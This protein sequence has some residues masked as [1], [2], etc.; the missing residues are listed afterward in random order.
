MHE[1]LG[2]DKVWWSNHVNTMVDERVKSEILGTDVVG[3]TFEDQRSALVLEIE[4]HLGSVEGRV[5]ETVNE[6]WEV[7]GL[8]LQEQINATGHVAKLIDDKVDDLNEQL[9]KHA[10][11]VAAAEAINPKADI[12]VE[13]AERLAAIDTSFIDKAHSAAEEAC[14]ACAEMRSE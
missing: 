10:A 5:E 14:A 13:I 6:R 1:E 12:A 11:T 2:R 9:E 3:R 4:A 7:L 8:A